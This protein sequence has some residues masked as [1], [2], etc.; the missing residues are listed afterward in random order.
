MLDS[1]IHFSI[2][3]KLII[4]L[5]T[6]ALVAWGTYSISILP[7]DAVPYITDNQVMIITVTPTLAA[8]EAERLI[9]FQ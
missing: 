5:F 2:R 3:N 8:Q 4:G 9:T 7:I 6:L 1:I